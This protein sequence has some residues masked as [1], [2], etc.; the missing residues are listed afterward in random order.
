[1]TTG[2]D[3]SGI[4][5]VSHGGTEPVIIPLKKSENRDLEDWNQF[6]TRRRGIAFV[7]LCVVASPVQSME[8]AIGDSC[9]FI[10]SWRKLD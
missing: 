9:H 6:I 10:R 1:M 2:A 4:P 7:R 5:G 3:I 8:R